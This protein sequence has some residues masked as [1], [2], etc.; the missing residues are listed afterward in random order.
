[1]ARVTSTGI[2]FSDATSLNSRYG[3][4]PKNADVI[5]CEV[6]APTGWT[7][8]TTHN[9]KAL[10]VVNTNGAGSSGNVSFT[11]AFSIQPISGNVPVTITGLAGNP[12]TLAPGEIP[13]HTHPVNSGGN[14]SCAPGSPAAGFVTV[15]APGSVTGNN[16][17]GG[18]AHGHPVTYTA[19]NG[20][21]STTMDLRVAYVDV[22]I[23]N[24]D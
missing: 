16:P 20:P 10:R 23:C 9:N 15:V 5:F 21:F 4:I 22:I 13:S 7:Q 1:M 8:V 6:S 19:A 17:G 12:H 24:F 2:N 11:S 18:G 14:V 3:I